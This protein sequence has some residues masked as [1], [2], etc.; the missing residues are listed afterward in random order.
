LRKEMSEMTDEKKSF[1]L[2]RILTLLVRAWNHD[3]KRRGFTDTRKKVFEYIVDYKKEKG[4]V[5]R[6]IQIAKQFG[7]S[8]QNVTPILSWLNKNNKIKLWKRT[9]RYEI[10]NG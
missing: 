3:S 9:R 7:W 1:W 5:P 8:R 2:S 10:I 6:P 4:V